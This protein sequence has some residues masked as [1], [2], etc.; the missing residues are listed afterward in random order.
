MDIRTPDKWSCTVLLMD[1]FPEGMLFFT[2]LIFLHLRHKSCN[3][4]RQLLQQK[5]AQQQ[6]HY[7]ILKTCFS[8]ESH[9]ALHTHVSIFPI[10]KPQPELQ[11]THTESS[12]I[13]ATQATETVWKL[14]FLQWQPWDITFNSSR[15]SHTRYKARTKSFQTGYVEHWPNM[16]QLCTATCHKVNWL[17]MSVETVFTTEHCFLCN[18]CLNVFMICSVIPIKW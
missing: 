15:H 16:T 17:W 7:L 18:W 11:H 8:S 14:R 2:I 6:T 3:H 1:I 13:M 9:L 5:H 12:S 4:C 10:L